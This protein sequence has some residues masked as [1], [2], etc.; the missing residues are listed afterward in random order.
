MENNKNEFDDIILEKSN[1]S[2]KMK[3]NSPT[4]HCFG[5]FIFSNY[6]SNETY[7]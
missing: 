3:K 4:R 2:E 6:D 5:D 1:K 7:Q